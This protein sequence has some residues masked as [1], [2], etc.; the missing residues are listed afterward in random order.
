M[1]PRLK[2][3]ALVALLVVS[4]GAAGGCSEDFDAGSSS[5]EQLCTVL[6]S[7]IDLAD[8]ADPFRLEPL[9]EGGVVGVEGAEGALAPVVFGYVV[10]RSSFDELGPYEPAIRFAAAM[11]AP[12]L[13]GLLASAA[14]APEVLDSARAVDRRLRTGACVRSP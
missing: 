13:E 3:V 8:R 2:A 5:E 12:D 4:A 11:V 10:H 14:P 1:G 7:A 9:V 6:R